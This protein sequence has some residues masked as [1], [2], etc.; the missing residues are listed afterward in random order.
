MPDVSLAGVRHLLHWAMGDDVD[1]KSVLLVSVT[2]ILLISFAI[3]Y[4]IMRGRGRRVR[5]DW[6]EALL[7][8]NLGGLYQIADI[9]AHIL[10]VGAASLLV[11]RFRLF[12]IPVTG[13]TVLPIMLGVEFYYYWFHRASHRIRWF[14]SAH[15]VHH[16]STRMDLSTAMRQGVLYPVTGWWL[17][18]LPLVWLGVPPGVVF[19]LY[20]VDLFYQ[21][22]V[23]TESVGR[24]PGWIEYV[25]D[26]PSN[27][28]VHHGRNAGYLDRNYGG[29]IVIFDRWFGTYVAETVPVEYGI[30]PPRHLG[31]AVARWQAGCATRSPSTCT[32]SSRC[33]ATSPGP[34]GGRT[35]SAICGGRQA[36]RGRS[37]R[38]V[39]RQACAPSRPRRGNRRS[40]R[41]R[42]CPS[43]RG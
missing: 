23:H 40:A 27:H 39:R 19:L 38:V 11:Y 35:G 2:P 20:G 43:P 22:F 25:F 5:Y 7:N 26:T 1:W 15:V 12:D 30:V 24:L 42:G 10:F 41:N 33:G 13:W 34:A 6:G 36:G 3:E 18:F 31:G 16:S 29:M 21:F 17:F 14:W 32:S 8:A 28:R 4:Q 9:G 37:G